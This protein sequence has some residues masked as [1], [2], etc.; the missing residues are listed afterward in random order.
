MIRMARIGPIDQDSTH[1]LIG[2][3]IAS[4]AAA[5]LLLRD[6]RID[7]RHIRIIEQ[8]DTLGGSLDGS[9]NAQAGYLMRGGRM[10]EEHFACTFALFD[11]IP[12]IDDPDCS[13]S[14]D[15][16]AFNHKVV[17]QSR[18]RLVRNGRKAEDR[19]SLKLG[20]PDRLA[21]ARLMLARESGLAGRTIDSWFRQAFFDSNF[22][23]FWSTMFSFSPW[24]SLVE[25]RRY[26]RRFIHL[27]PGLPTLSGIQRTR[28]N[29]YDSLILPLQ[30]WLSERGVTFTTGRAVTDVEIAGDTRAR[31]VTRIRLDDGEE[32]PVKPEDRVYLT[33]GSMTDGATYGSN[34]TVPPQLDQPGASWRLWQ[35]LARTQRDLGRPEVFCGEPASTAWHSFTVTL[36]HPDF[37]AFMEQFSGNPSGTGGLVTFADSAW[38]M[39]IVMAHQPHFRDQPPGTLVFWGYGLR[40]DHRGNAVN[41]SMW[42]ANGEEIL[43]ELA[44]Q[45]RLDARQRSWFEGARI[46]PC[47]MPF[48]TSQFMP[49]LA[50][51]RPPVH[52]KGAGNF[53][54]IGQFCE[55]ARDCVFTVEYS[56]RSAWE[57]VTAMTG[58]ASPA[59]PVARTDR[60]PMVLMRAMRSLLVG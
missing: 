48:I 1:I 11:S 56:V 17:S 28:Y 40:G 23:L 32:I 27:F 43:A 41:K 58:N 29:Q 3:G 26:M 4:L 44:F 52:P 8:S 5:T 21:L 39:S 34:H 60:D 10:F 50:G 49:R 18:C 20:W 37:H 25:M 22:W 53:A 15:I 51:D 55:L 31:L 16:A 7:G 45:L 35:R 2:G 14:A 54:V 19:Y 33:L 59:P 24:H 57:A 12:S 6:A 47:R 42:E 36:D 46:I 30:R 13:V 38:L 9:G